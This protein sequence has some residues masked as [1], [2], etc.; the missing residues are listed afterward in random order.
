MLLWTL[1]CMYLFEV[2]FSFF[3]YTSRS[4]ID[5]S[6]GSSIFSFLRHIHTVF[7]RGHTNLRSHQQCMRVP[8][9]PHPHQRLLFVFCLMIAILTSVRWHLTVVLICIFLVINDVEHLFMWLLAICM[10]SL[11]KYLLRSSAHFLIG[12]FFWCWIVWAVYICWI[13]IPYQSYHL[14]ILCTY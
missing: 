13:L 5:G 6:Y 2:E 9:S 1:G 8:F 3:G 4:G 11:K 12:L 7:H 10:F 14:P